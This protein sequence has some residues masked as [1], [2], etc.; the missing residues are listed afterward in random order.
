MNLPTPKHP[1]GWQC[2]QDQVC[3]AHTAYDVQINGVPLDIR[4]SYKIAVNDYIAKGGSGFKV[5]KRNTTRIETGISM[6]DSLIDYMRG[7]CTCEEILGLDPAN[8]GRPDDQKVSSAGYVCARS[9]DGEQ[10]VI[11]PVAL[12]W[13]KQAVNFSNLYRQWQA[14][15]ASVPLPGLTDGM[16]S[17][18][19]VMDDNEVACKGP[20]SPE[21]RD[22]CD[23]STGK[24]TCAAVAAGDESACGHITAD[25]KEFCVS[26]S[27]VPIAIAEEDGR[28]GRRVK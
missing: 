14:D 7:Q 6:R 23:L 20:I 9:L 11:D 2:T 4:A 26:P 21:L 28:I 1:D 12:A 19:E 8:Q 17:C 10:R 22:F 18:V 24:C 13:C 15:P 27:K 16:C 25:L 3:W 5:L